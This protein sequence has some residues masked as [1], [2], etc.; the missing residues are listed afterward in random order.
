MRRLLGLL[1]VAC[2]FVSSVQ[3]FAQ[4]I[5]TQ[6]KIFDPN[7]L[8]FIQ[9]NQQQQEA[10]GYEDL[11]GRW[12]EYDEYR[13]ESR[14]MQKQNTMSYLKDRLTELLLNNGLNVTEEADDADFI[15]TVKDLS[16]FDY[17]GYTF[18]PNYTVEFTVAI[19]PKGSKETISSITLY[20]E[21]EETF[22]GEDNDNRCIDYI[23]TKVLGDQ[24]TFTK[25]CNLVLDQIVN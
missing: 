8:F 20:Y 15:L 3:V 4:N 22:K 14:K 23:F 5:S 6:T 12:V 19:N 18:G 17:T 9:I 10:K 16:L 24:E 13:Y 11:Q 1:V 21:I 25:T 7:K 2:I